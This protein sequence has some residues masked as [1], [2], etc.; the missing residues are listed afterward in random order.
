MM[1]WLMWGAVVFVGLFALVWVFPVLLLLAIPILI[2]GG[3]VYAVINARMS[4]KIM[5][6]VQGDKGVVK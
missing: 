4:Y 2:I 6:T 5:K 3:F 1:S